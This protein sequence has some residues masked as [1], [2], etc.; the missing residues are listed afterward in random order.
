MA[1]A[2]CA[3]AA[4]AFAPGENTVKSLLERLW[5]ETDGVLSFEWTILTSVVTIG[6]VAGIAAVRDAV[7]D[8]MADVAEAMTS[9]D[10]SYRIQGPL[11]VAV[12][13]P[14]QGGY[15]GTRVQ[16]FHRTPSPPMTPERSGASGAT[17]SAYQDQRG[18]VVRRSADPAPLPP[19]EA[20]GSLAAPAVDDNS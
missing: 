7:V 4:A 2:S 5:R 18:I 13:T 1:A 17:G 10:Q 3:L 16:E 9:L 12:H 14:Y 15:G 11:V 6:A 20:Q 8:E 19:P